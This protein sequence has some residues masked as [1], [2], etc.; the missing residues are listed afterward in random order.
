[1]YLIN[2]KMK[3]INFHRCPEGMYLYFRL[4][5]FYAYNSPFIGKIPFGLSQNEICI[6]FVKDEVTLNP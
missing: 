2:F 6:L 5:L 3:K 4:F 1:M